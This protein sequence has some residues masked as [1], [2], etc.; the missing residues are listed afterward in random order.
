MGL[1]RI[2]SWQDLS[3]CIAHGV[4]TIRPKSFCG[5][6]LRLGITK[7]YIP[8]FK[9]FENPVFAGLSDNYIATAPPRMEC[10]STPNFK[11]WW[12]SVSNRGIPAS[13]GPVGRGIIQTFAYDFRPPLTGSHSLSGPIH[14]LSLPVTPKDGR[15][16]RGSCSLGTPTSRTNLLFQT[17]QHADHHQRLETCHR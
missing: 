15:V 8:L 3:T 14:H 16:Y 12:L 10:P 17:C 11:F 13:M 6:L 1:Q 5:P 4:L 9:V 7:Y 2:F